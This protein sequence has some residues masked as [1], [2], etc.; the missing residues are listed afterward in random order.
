MPENHPKS[1]K[2]A[3]M[4]KIAK[5]RFSSSATYR[6]ILPHQGFSDNLPTFFMVFGPLM[7]DRCLVR[8]ISSLLRDLRMTYFAIHGKYVKF[9]Q[10]HKKSGFEFGLVHQFTT[11]NIG[12]RSVL[13]RFQGV[14]S[15]G[16]AMLLILYASLRGRPTSACD[17]QNLQKLN[18]IRSRPLSCAKPSETAILRLTSKYS[19][20]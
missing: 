15:H 20:S 17:G 7:N 14:S 13:Y 11:S 1:L 18:K 19:T 5:N 3:K 8:G 16:R 2:M 9:S 10:S 12:A 4:A 6:H